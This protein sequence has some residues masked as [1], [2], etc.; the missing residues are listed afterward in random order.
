[1]NE[2]DTIETFHM[3]LNRTFQISYDVLKDANSKNSLN[4]PLY[5]VLC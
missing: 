1:M 5:G 2:V 4:C 3:S